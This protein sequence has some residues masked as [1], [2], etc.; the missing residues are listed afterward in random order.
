MIVGQPL[1]LEAQVVAV[2]NPQIQWIKDG[3]PVRPTKEINFVNDPNGLIGLSIDKVRPEDAG[4][5]SL[6]VS[7]K[8]GDTTGTA[9][10]DV[11][12]KERKPGFLATLQPLTVVEGFPAKL[13]V[14]TV[15]KPPAELKWRHNGVEVR[16]NN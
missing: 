5:Y 4:T 13:E 3:V 9:K 15:G 11:V 14:K 10:V 8:L 12:E 2:P 6:V 7:N 1:K 16:I